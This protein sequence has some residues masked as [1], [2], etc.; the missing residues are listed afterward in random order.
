LP[1]LEW[2]AA[3][4]S[5]IPNRGEQMVRHY[6]YYS[7]LSQGKRQKNGG[8]NTMP[9]ILESEGDEKIVHWNWVRLIQKIYEVDPLVYPKYQG[10]MRIIDSIEDPSVI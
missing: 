1:A 2:L 9:F 6:G 10:A 4:C 5:H 8:D 3:M 7:N